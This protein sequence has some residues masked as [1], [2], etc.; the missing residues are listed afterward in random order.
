MTNAN[1]HGGR[2]TTTSQ[3]VISVAP[4]QNGHGPFLLTPQQAAATLAI[5]RRKLWSLTASGEIMC[6]R[7]GRLVRYR[8][9]DLQEFVDSLAGRA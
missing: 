8:P 7:I 6:V 5:G 2:S 9:G 3:G 1:F 4:T